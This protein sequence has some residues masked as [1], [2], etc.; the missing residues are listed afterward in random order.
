[1]NYLTLTKEMARA[2]REDLMKM[3]RLV[4]KVRRGRRSGIPMPPW[5]VEE[6]GRLF[7]MDD[8]GDY[9]HA[10][11]F[12][13]YGKPDDEIT[14]GTTWAVSVVW[15]KLKPSELP[16]CAIVW[17]YFMSD[18]KPV[19]F[20]KM[21]PAIF[22]PGFLRDQMPR[23]T[24][25]IVRA[26]RV[27]S[28]T[29]EESIMEGIREVT[30]DGQVFKYCVYDHSDYSSTPWQDMPRDARTAFKSLWNSINAKRGYGWESNPWVWVL[31]W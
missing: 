26:E 1:M 9:H 5:E 14:L 13:P 12:C 24:L 31:G 7:Y 11:D 28:I 10:E 8:F 18:E 3:I 25:K 19:G 30:K 23:E 27:Q 2:Y 16:D 21:R 29:A 4:V 15:D 6:D 17:S 20:G 22:L